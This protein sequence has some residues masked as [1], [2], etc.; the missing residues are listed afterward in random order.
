MEINTIYRKLQDFGVSATGLPLGKIIVANQGKTR[1]LKPFIDIT[2]SNYKSISKPIIREL[3]AGGVQTIIT[4]ATC[5]ATLR[6]F[7]D[8]LH[9][10]EILLHNYYNAFNTELRNA[11]FK[12]ELAL[13]RT[14]KTVTAMPKA[15]VDG[16]I[17]SYAVLDLELSF[18]IEV[19]DNVGFIE[20][21]SISDEILQKE[22]TVTNNI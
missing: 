5:T 19:K 17:E 14:L 9:A 18:N 21:V 4:P 1:P 8:G 11:V 13:H 6:A 3:D 10:A 7:A 15:M 16:A 2:I 12:G 22:Y 20:Q